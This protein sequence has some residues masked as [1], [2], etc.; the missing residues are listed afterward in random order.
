MNLIKIITDN[1]IKLSLT[2][3]RIS[4]NMNKNHFYL[5]MEIVNNGFPK[6]YYK[7]RT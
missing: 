1:K 2:N 6:T 7:I 3:K 5:K 4:F